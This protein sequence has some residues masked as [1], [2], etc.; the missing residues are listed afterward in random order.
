MTLLSLAIF[1]WS[2][3]CKINFPLES[4][5]FVMMINISISSIIATCHETI[6]CGMIVLGDQLVH[7]TFK[8]FIGL[9]MRMLHIV[10]QSPFLWFLHLA[11]QFVFWFAIC[12]VSQDNS[13]FDLWLLHLAR[14]FV[15][16]FVITILSSAIC[17]LIFD[18]YVSQGNSSFDGMIV[19]CH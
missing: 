6:F 15:F 3:V 2:V 16:W 19:V 1:F 14:Q 9:L 13:S 4:C 5:E 17:L 11:G 8:A 18:C 10:E 7:W 12:C